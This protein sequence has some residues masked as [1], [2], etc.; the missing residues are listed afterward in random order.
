M[1]NGNSGHAIHLYNNVA[2]LLVVKKAFCA[3]S[4]GDYCHMDCAN[5]AICCNEI[6][7]LL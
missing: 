1:C 2:E 7:E 4:W 6:H 3:C 5:T